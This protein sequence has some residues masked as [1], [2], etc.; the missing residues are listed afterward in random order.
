MFNFISLFTEN[1]IN[2][3]LSICHFT[4]FF[5]EFSSCHFLGSSHWSPERSNHCLPFQ[6]PSWR[7]C[8]E[9]S[10]RLRKP[11]D[12]SCSSYKFPSRSFTFFTALLWM[13]SSSFMI[14]LIL[15]HSKLHIS[16]E[17]C[18]GL[19]KGYCLQNFCAL[20]RLTSGIHPFFCY[21]SYLWWALASAYAPWNI[22]ITLFHKIFICRMITLE[23]Y[24]VCFS[25]QHPVCAVS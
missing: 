10:S 9:I 16:E 14:L 3:S 11:S 20:L 8:S 6:F 15:W 12:L 18:Q 17:Q 23:N 19:T 5:L 4:A 2:I 7:S 24:A 1:C 21:F 22:R 25:F 13:A